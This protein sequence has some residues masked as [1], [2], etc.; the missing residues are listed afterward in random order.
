MTF[1]EFFKTGIFAKAKL[2]K[3]IAT[4]IKMQLNLLWP[5]HERMR[6][7]LQLSSESGSLL[8][9]LV[10][11]TITPTPTNLSHVWQTLA[12]FNHFP[13]VC[14]TVVNFW[15]SCLLLAVHLC[16]SQNFCLTSL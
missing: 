12:A 5:V 3:G 4:E 13:G 6:S 15:S 1:T 8:A 11:E 10:S 14:P 2:S 16:R 9:D 7:R